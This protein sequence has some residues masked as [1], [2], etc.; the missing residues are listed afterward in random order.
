[1]EIRISTIITSDR[2]EPKFQL[3][4]SR[5]CFSITSPYS[6]KLPLPNR[7]DIAKVVTAGTHTTVTKIGFR[8]AMEYAER[9][10]QLLDA[11]NR[12]FEENGLTA[13]KA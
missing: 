4:N 10:Y 6:M 11:M 1:M 7:R 2:L 5:H 13:L 12:I 8:I 9:N 3:F